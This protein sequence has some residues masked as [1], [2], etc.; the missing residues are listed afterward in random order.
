MC[1]HNCRENKRLNNLILSGG[2]YHPFA[3]SSAALA[4]LFLEQGIHST[5]Y[6]DMDLGLQALAEGDFQ[7]LTVNALRWR[8][9][10]KKYDPYR[11]EWAF[12][13]SAEQ[14]RTISEHVKQG[15][16]LFG[17]HT[18]SICFDE[19]QEWQQ[20]LGGQWQWGRSWHYPL[21]PVEVQ[22]SRTFDALESGQRM[23]LNDEVYTDLACEPTLTVLLESIATE[24]HPAQPLAWQHH[25][26]K[27][28]VF[29][30]ALGHD[31]ASINQ[32]EH[33]QLIRAAAAWLQKNHTQ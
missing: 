1:F 2:I 7:L 31:Q 13:L 10:G 24:Q 32:A 23:T 20:I 25:Y 29:Y 3:E 17:L 8:M 5:V 6:E 11:D 26:G 9:H 14:Q 28:R 19:W 12:S 33:A 22:V 18:A 27:G 21:G 15:G 30:D 4:A 16:C